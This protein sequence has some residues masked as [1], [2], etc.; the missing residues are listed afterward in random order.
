MDLK[1][2]I[3]SI[4][5]F[6]EKGII[7]RDITTLLKE[8]EG[9]HQAIEQMEQKL[10]GLEYDIVLGPESRGFLFGMPIAYNQKK[11]FVPVRKKGKLPAK[12]VSKE[13]ALEY[14]VATIEIH[15]DAI[16]KGQKV[17][18]VDDLLATGGTAK[19]IVE[20]VEEMGAEVVA[21]DFLIELEELQGRKT[22]QGYRVESVVK[23]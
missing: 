21:L 23:Y 18:I 20:M 2:K 7:F 13:Y 1:S 9:M 10:E 6:P 19:A 14:G 4:A 17:V 15:Q 22:L 5:D 3:R 11:G 12:T 8:A 16:E